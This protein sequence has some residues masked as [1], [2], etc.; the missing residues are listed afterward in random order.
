MPYLASNPKLASA[1]LANA[2]DAAWSVV[3]RPSANG[4]SST[5]LAPD[6]TSRPVS[7]ADADTRR[8][9]CDPSRPAAEIG[10]GDT[11]DHSFT[12]RTTRR[13]WMPQLWDAPR[14]EEH[15][16]ELQSQSNLVCR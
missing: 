13:S 10:T 2:G 9:P 16:S 15:T 5:F 14:S 8:M 11:N 1:R 7:V 4:L 6:G 12:R 3:S